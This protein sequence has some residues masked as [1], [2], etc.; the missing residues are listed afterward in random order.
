[1]SYTKVSPTFTA[2]PGLR[3]VKALS[4]NLNQALVVKKSDDYRFSRGNEIMASSHCYKSLILTKATTIKEHIVIA[5]DASLNKSTNDTGLELWIKVEDT[6]T[7]AVFLD[8]YAALT[9]EKLEMDSSGKLIYTIGDGTDTYA[10]T[11]T[12]DMRDGKWHHVFCYADRDAEAYIYLDG[13]DD[14]ASRAGTL[15]N[16]DSITTPGDLL[17]GKSGTTYA[18]R[19][20]MDE[21]R[22]WVWAGGVPAGIANAISENYRC[23]YELS[24]YLSSGDLAL[25]LKFDEDAGGTFADETANNND[26]TPIQ[27][28]TP[29]DCSEVQATSYIVFP[30]VYEHAVPHTGTIAIRLKCFW[31]ADDST[32]HCLFYHSYSSDNYI[33]IEKNASNNLVFTVKS[34]GTA[35]SC[36][37]DV[38]TAW[39]VGNW[40]SVV[41]YWNINRVFNGTDYLRLK[42]DVLTANAVITKPE[43]F[44]NVG[45]TWRIGS[46][47]TYIS[48]AIIAY[49]I[50][51]VPWLTT[52]MPFYKNQTYWYNSGDFN[53]PII[54]QYTIG[55]LIS[56]LGSNKPQSGSLI[57][58]VLL[59]EDTETTDGVGHLKARVTADVDQ[60]Y[61]GQRLLIGVPLK[62]SNVATWTDW[63][64][65]AKI[66]AA[67]ITDNGDGTITLTFTLSLNAAIRANYTTANAC[68]ITNNLVFDGHCENFGSEAWEVANANI[69]KDQH[70]V[71][72][73]RQSLRV[74]A[75]AANGYAYSFPISV[76]ADENYILSMAMYNEIANNC[77]VIVYDYTNSV[78]IFDTGALS[79]TQ[80]QHFESSF[81]I[82]AGCTQIEIRLYSVVSTGSAN[83]DAIMLLKDY[84][85][86][87]G[88]EGTYVAEL[89]PGWTKTSTPTLLESADEN[90]G[91]KAQSVDGDSSNYVTQT[92]AV[93]VGKWYTFT[94]FCK[95]TA[96]VI[97]LSGTTTKTLTYTSDTMYRKLGFTFKAAT[98]SLVIKAYGN[99]VA[100]LFDDFSVQLLTIKEA[101]TS[102][103]SALANCYETDKWSNASKAFSLHGG[104]NI[105]YSSAGVLNTDIGTIV[106][107]F[108]TPFAYNQFD[109]RDFYLFEI[110]NVFRLWYDE[111]EAKFKFQIWDGAAFTTAESAAQT[112]TAGTWLYITCTYDNTAGINIWVNVTEG[113]EVSDTWTEQSLPTYIYFWSDK[114]GAQ[115]G[116]GTYDF[117]HGMD[118]VLTESQI[119][120][121]VA[122]DFGNR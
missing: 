13:A 28:A 85:D 48:D 25:W 4:G 91:A 61:A 21:V 36:T 112:F 23:P 93:E 103:P 24:G 33:K 27:D 83:Y 90:S 7:A 82:P 96:C 64:E 38:S 19:V 79:R 84:V 35:Q 56:E 81:E 60:F 102:T 92:V 50:D 18:T 1:M 3:P 110:E 32:N 120:A 119:T 109:D 62:Y 88:F 14:S 66:D 30:L 39:D 98:T 65:V 94:G 26:G 101:S 45:S 107:P 20:S 118:E 5:D 89:A 95:G 80:Y 59:S 15:A 2:L 43:Q 46:D 77:R 67:G 69:I 49:Q 74:R 75:T 78:N 100:C 71:F 52:Y 10:V 104:S 111:S 99:A 114:D 51:S 22:S 106:I 86:N 116:D 6:A 11:G 108:K 73:G 8:R 42:I 37:V 29:V 44:E 16:V 41:A 47:G 115:Q 54:D 117:P 72:Q 97:D 17:I 70:Q 40:Y 53:L 121:I 105:K 58:Q 57:F 113:G 31:S 87:G 122:G 68:F 76:A 12:A 55:C 9:G 34:G 63:W